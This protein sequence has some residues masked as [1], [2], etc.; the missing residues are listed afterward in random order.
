[1]D[2]ST[3][4]VVLAKDIMNTEVYSVFPDTTIKEVARIM[5]EKRISAVPVV[6]K[7]QE[8]LGVVSE[9]DL[10]HKIVKPHEPG[11]WTF[12][13]HAMLKS[14]SE[15]LEYRKALARWNAQTAE[16]AMTSPVLCVDKNEPV[17]QVA[18]KMMENKVKRVIVEEEGH[19]AGIISRADFVKLIFEEE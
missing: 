7:Y 8:V 10:I 11:I 16:E 15:V 5:I 17:S 14:K 9:G 19:L 18:E 3:E 1:M 6:S 13:S 4:K 2:N 12:L